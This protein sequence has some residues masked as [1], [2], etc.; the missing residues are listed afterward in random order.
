MKSRTKQLS[1]KPKEKKKTGPKT[2]H[3]DRLDKIAFN[4]ASK[5][6]SNKEIYETL[7]ITEQCGIKWKKLYKSF[8]DAIK[9]GRSKLRNDLVEK[10]LLKIAMG[11]EAYTSKA[12]VVSDGKDMGA[13]IEKV[14]V[15]EYYPPQ[16]NAIKFFLTNRKAIADY[17]KEGWA[18]KQSIEHSG[19]LNY[20]VTPDD[21]LEPEDK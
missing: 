20:K 9:D 11:H 5:G 13:H 6:K 14:R 15:K 17:G 4:L 21:E 8:Y 7:G 3:N 10:A 12:L 1:N 19:T 18:E 16:V 2:L